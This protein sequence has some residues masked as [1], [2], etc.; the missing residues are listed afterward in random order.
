MQTRR[1]QSSGGVRIV[2]AHPLLP[3]SL[4]SPL[5]ADIYTTSSQVDRDAGSGAPASV[6]AYAA[7]RDEYVE[8]RDWAGALTLLDFQRQAGG[9][10]SDSASLAWLG[11]CAFHAGDYKR[12]IDAFSSV[13][14]D[15]NSNSAAVAEAHLNVACCYFYLQM[16][17]EAKEAA[18]RGPDNA[19]KNRLMF[20][21]SHRLNEEEEVLTYHQNL[22][23][24]IHDQ[25]SLAALHFC[26]VH[27][28]EATEIYKRLLVENRDDL[29]LNLYVA[30]CY[31]KLDYYDV[32]LEILAVYLQRYPKSSVALNMKACNHFRLYNDKA[33]MAELKPLFDEGL[34]RENDL[35]RHN[36]VVFREGAKALQ[37]LPQLV[38]F[39]PEARL[40]LVIYYLRNDDVKEAYALIKDL[41]P[42]T[43]PEYIL[44]GIV[45]ANIGQDTTRCVRARRTSRLSFDLIDCRVLAHPLP[46]PRPSLRARARSRE[47]LKF[48]Q[49]FFQLVGASSQECDTIPGRQCMASCFFLLKQFDD[50]NIYLKSIK[51][52]LHTEDAFNWNYGLSLAATGSYAEA[53]E[54]LRKVQSETLQKDFVFLSWLAR[55]CI[56]NGSPRTAWDVYLKMETSDES[57]NLLRLIANDCYRMGHFY[58]AAKAFDVLERLDPDPEYWQGK[59]GACIGVFQKVL[60]EEEDRKEILRDVIAILKYNLSEP[61]AETITARMVKVS[62]SAQRPHSFVSR[63]NSTPFSLRC[64]YH[65]T[66]EHEGTFITTHARTYSFQPCHL[67]RAQWCRE[68]GVKGV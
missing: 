28:Q 65:A 6:E 48:A 61:D 34:H 62:V 32:S 49:Q 3:R 60:A 45:M 14:R 18:Q 21:V 30:M 47:H 52:Y 44:K 22:S 64:I 55:C 57:F 36:I 56:M 68:N 16:W 15:A 12:A 17:E 42:C 38:D 54:H 46:S 29:A 43:P 1:R 58:H 41:E 2:A 63:S 53:E 31:Y 9:S 59:R 7:Q 37:I 19:L 4:R 67:K 24:S 50:V 33:A 39:V 13:A 27:Y 8:R 66:P 11:Y 26:R 20:H 40:N 51:P 5:T 10:A 35:V 25:L 23:E